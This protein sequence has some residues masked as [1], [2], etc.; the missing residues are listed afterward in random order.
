MSDYLDRDGWDLAYETDGSGPAVILCHALGA[1][2]GMWEGQLATL[3]T[4][5]LV[6]RFDH[7]GHGGSST[8]PGPYTMADLGG[9][10]IALADAL[11]VDQF[12]FCGVSMGG[13]VGMWL[14]TN[15][16]DRVGRLVLANTGPRIGTIDAWQDRI[17]KVSRGGMESIVDM[18]IERFFTSAWRE[19][20]PQ[21]VAS[22]RETLLRIDPEGYVACCAAVRD[23]D[24]A[25]EPTSI[26]SPTLLIAGRHDV[27]TPLAGLEDLLAAIPDAELVV[28]DA[29]HLSNVEAPEQFGTALSR[30]L[31]G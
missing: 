12:D 26:R 16:P 28:L 2:Q 6:I 8:P 4:R 9:D 22:A 1:D 3:R 31:A 18:V 14:A 10:V 27:S 20:H 17:D 7:R 5:R 21:E 24:F 23:T 13:Q 29:A 25:G 11:G 15:H 30:H 19:G